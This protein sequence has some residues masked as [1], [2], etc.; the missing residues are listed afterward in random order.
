MIETRHP[1]DISK[2]EH[3]SPR[4]SKC[5]MGRSKSPNIPFVKRTA[6]NEGILS[7][8]S[9]DEIRSEQMYD[10]ATWRMYHRITNARKQQRLIPTGDFSM[11]RRREGERHIYGDY[12]Q[13][14]ERWSDVQVTNIL[15]RE[16]GHLQ[17]NLD[18]EDEKD[19]DEIFE[20]DMDC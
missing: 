19:L 11:I 17:Q 10:R 14:P 20:L 1:Y 6:R 18:V 3:A 7:P 5:S 16:S 2:H 12:S 15:G 4:F 9:I 8:N 13:F